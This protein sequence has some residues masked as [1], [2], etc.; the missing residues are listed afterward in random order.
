MKLAKEQLVTGLDYNETKDIN[1]CE[2]CVNGKHHCFSFPKSGEKQASQLLETVHSDV[3]GRT[4]AKSLGGAKYFITFIDGK[5]RFVWLYMLKHKEEVFRKFIEW[6]AMV[7][8]SSG[9]RVKTLWTE[10]GRE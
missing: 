2:P 3:C 7:E 9:K 4:E 10:N 8:K 5:S 6:K 1:F